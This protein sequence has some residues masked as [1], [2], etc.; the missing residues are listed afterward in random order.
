MKKRT[1]LLTMTTKICLS[2]AMFL[3][4]TIVLFSEEKR[5]VTAMLEQKYAEVAFKSKGGIEYYYLFNE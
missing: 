5:S 2:L 1:F 3:I 4:Q